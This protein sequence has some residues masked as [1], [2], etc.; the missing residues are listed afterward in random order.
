MC[1]TENADIPESVLDFPAFRDYAE[2][3]IFFALLDSNGCVVEANK[4]LLGL[5][6]LAS[7]DLQLR[8]YPLVASDQSSLL[9][10]EAIRQEI[11]SKELW[12]GIISNRAIDGK[13]FWL[14]ATIV[15]YREI[16]C[17]EASYMVSAVNISGAMVV[18]DLLKLQEVV[19]NS[20]AEGVLITGRD[21]EIQWINP[22]YEQMTGY[23][24][25]EIRGKG[26]SIFKSGRQKG[27]FYRHL[28]NT[29][30][31]GQVWQGEL[32]NSRKD[33]SEYLEEQSIT[34]VVGACG[35]ITHL[36]AIKRDV[37]ERNELRSRLNQAKRIE[38]ISQLTSG[39]A[40]NFN[41]KLASILGYSELAAEVAEKRQDTVLSNY[42][43]EIIAAAKEAR[44]LVAQMRAFSRKEAPTLQQLQ[45][46]VLLMEFYQLLLS[47]MPNSIHISTQIEPDLPAIEGDVAQ[48][49]QMFMNLCI[50]ARDA[51]AG[52]G[53]L[54]IG[55]HRRVPKVDVCN[56]CHKVVSGEYIE[57][58]VGDTGGGI[59]PDILPDIFQPFFGTNGLAS[60]AGMGLSELHGMLHEHGGHILID[61]HVGHGTIIRLLLPIANVPKEAPDG[62]AEKVE[63]PEILM[64]SKGKILIVDDDEAL[65]GFIQEILTDHGFSVVVE[66]S[67]EQALRLFDDSSTDFDLIV[68]DLFMPD[69]S[70]VELMQA[71]ESISPH[72]P[73]VM[74]S[75]Y[76]EAFDEGS[77]KPAMQVCEFIAKPFS[78]GELIALIE[79]LIISR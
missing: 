79:G 29:V 30:L 14:S 15:A 61:N 72:L 23:S 50:N 3:R 13:A 2:D 38:A 42:V 28:W 63:E 54:E 52:V 64:A 17:D 31:S 77:E 8:K 10:F 51:M 62:P 65:A 16:D 33:G 74:M 44:D 37:T 67:G 40:H 66:N 70:G 59:D 26:T 45:P 73:V 6:G 7:G 5:I 71:L 12:R 56:A 48:L 35:K 49:Q 60:N 69:M 20:V 46:E 57:L 36:I 39:I 68:T 19:L 18:E 27:A 11:E 47:V 58:S 9:S 75:G 1:K 22:A 41:N 78:G 34:P 43:S 32:W 24:L 55:L 25:E 21:G 4:K 76:G 53:E